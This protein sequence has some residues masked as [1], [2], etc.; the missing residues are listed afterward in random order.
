MLIKLFLIGS[1]VLIGAWLLRGQHRGNRLALARII[2]LLIGAAWIGSVLWPD[3]LTWVANR[4]GVR[5]GTDLLLYTLVV[6]FTF[7]TLQNRK[8]TRQL[9][10]KITTLARSNALLEREIEQ[11][12]SASGVRG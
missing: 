10:A 3:T 2:G 6:A 1:V 9:E 12:T 11:G 4:V 8:A 5:R 7:T